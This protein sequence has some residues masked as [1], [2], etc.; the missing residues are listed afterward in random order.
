MTDSNK[1][2]C[3]VGN[4]RVDCPTQTTTGVN[5]INDRLDVLPNINVLNKRSDLIFTSIFLLVV[6]SFLLSAIFKVKIFGKTLDE[7][8]KPIWYFVLIAVAVVAWQYLF[9]TNLD[10]NSVQL[11]ISQW[12][13]EAAVL[14]SAYKLSK[15]PDFGYG[16]MFFL[17]IIYSVLIHGLKVSVRYFFYAKTLLYVLDRF[18]YGSFL[19]MVF[20]F[21]LGSVFVYLKRK[22]I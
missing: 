6:L 5:Q 8:I 1:N 4:Q 16:N 12:V 18:I 14:I 2:D 11:R 15:V 21:I 9:G 3:F 7:Y 22:N 17:G 10:P 13:W 20:A 19:V